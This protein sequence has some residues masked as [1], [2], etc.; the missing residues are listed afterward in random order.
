MNSELRGRQLYCHSVNTSGSEEIQH[1]FP[2]ILF[3]VQFKFYFT[4]GTRWS[5]V[6]LILDVSGM[7]NGTHFRKLCQLLGAELWEA[8]LSLGLEFTKGLCFWAT[9]YKSQYKSHKPWTHIFLYQNLNTGVLVCSNLNSPIEDVFFVLYVTWIFL[10]Q[11]LWDFYDF[12]SFYQSRDRELWWEWVITENW[13]NLCSFTFSFFKMEYKID[14][15]YTKKT[16]HIFS[17][18]KHSNDCLILKILVL[19]SLFL[20]KV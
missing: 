9:V 20:H 11:I 4:S 5:M 7:L 6:G 10:L 2:R 17:K 13:E 18:K 12:M 16:Q 8:I 1:T 19:N 14:K 15:T 3:Q